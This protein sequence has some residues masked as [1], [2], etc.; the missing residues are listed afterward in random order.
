MNCKTTNLI[1]CI[2]CVGCHEHYIGQTVNSLCERVRVHKEQIKHPQYRNSP[3][4]SHIDTCGNKQF[5]IMPIFKCRRDNDYR[6]EMEHYFIRTFQSKLNP[7]NSTRSTM[8][9]NTGT[10]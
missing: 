9:N 8:A 6:K 4:S 2:T 3:V 1:Y 10:S 5:K 7:E